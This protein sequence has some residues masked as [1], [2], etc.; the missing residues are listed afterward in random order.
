MIKDVE[1]KQK[2]S[3]E[4]GGIIASQRN[5]GRLARDFVSLYFLWMDTI[6]LACKI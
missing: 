6:R 1:R 2:R 3:W 4:G 5:L